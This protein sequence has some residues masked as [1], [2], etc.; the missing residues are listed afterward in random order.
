MKTFGKHLLLLLVLLAALLACASCGGGEVELS[1]KESNLPQTVYVKGSG[2]NLTGGMLTVKEGDTEK[3][4]PLTSEGITVSGYDQNKLGDQTLTVTYRDKTVTFT[5]TVVERLQ[6]TGH[7][8][9]YLVGG[10]LD[11]AKGRLKI[12]RNDG[13][14]YTAV[15][16]DAGVSITG[17]DKTKTGEQIL[18]VTYRDAADTFT[19][20]FP[21]TVYAVESVKLTEPSKIAYNSHESNLLDVTGGRLTLSGKGGA[22][23][24]D[25]PLNADMVTGFDLSAV[26]AQN[27][28]Y[29]QTLTV[30]YDGKTYTYKVKLVYTS[31]SLIKDGLPAFDGLNFGGET[32]PAVTKEVGELALRLISVYLDMPAA[33]KLKLTA[34]ESLTVAR[35]A[36]IYGYGVWSGE[37]E[38]LSDSFAVKNGKLTPAFKTRADAEAA[39]KLLENKESPLYTVAPLLTRTVEAFGDGTV[40]GK[41]TFSSY[42]VLSASL[43]DGTVDL[44][45]YML[46]LSDIFGEIGADWES[47]G[48]MTYETAVRAA[49]ARMCASTFFTAEYAAAH[50]CVAAWGEFD[51]FEALYA[52]FFEKED[53][54][55]IEKLAP[56]CL[57]GEL[58]ELYGYVLNAWTQLALISEYEL[59]DATGFFYFYAKALDA[60]TF[61]R[62]EG[63]AIAELYKTMPINGILGLTDES[64]IYFDTMLEYF[65]T[66]NGGSVEYFAASLLGVEKFERLLGTYIEIVTRVLE[67]EGFEGSAAYGEAVRAMFAAYTALSPTEQ[68]NFLGVISPY[69]YVGYPPLAF[70]DSGEYAPLVSTFVTIL[71]GHF[72]SLFSNE[73][74]AEAYNNLVLAM[75]IYAQRATYE[76]DWLTALDLRLTKANSAYLAMDD[77]DKAVYERYLKALYTKYNDLYKS[78]KNATE[79]DLGDW[80]TVFDAL[81][82]AVIDF[83]NAY[84][85][86][87]DLGYP[88]YNL[89]LSAYERMEAI[90][91]YILEEAPEEVREAYYHANLYKIVAADGTYT[92]SYDYI[93][94]LDRGIYIDCLL[95]YMDNFYVYGAYT[96][97][98]LG[99]FLDMAYDTL[100]SYAWAYVFGQEEVEPPVF[101]RENVLALMAA[102]RELGRDAKLL[103]LSLEGEYGFYYAAVQAFIAEAFSEKASA[104][105]SKTVELEQYMYYL[106]LSN[107]ENLKT[108]KDMLAETKRLYTALAGADKSDF[109]DMEAFY[110]S[111]IAECEKAVAAAESAA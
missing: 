11:L 81:E 93:V 34:E 16:T 23:T 46:E 71:N 73:E 97:E 66:A 13:S 91:A 69:Y 95:G 94:G 84:Y 14:T 63:G 107:A 36:M 85:L 110:A 49:Y 7:V 29:E 60:A 25:I 38:K 19:A 52:Y 80:Q 54:E 72:R 55:A 31:I 68:L 105:A 62:A 102:F 1:V 89:L 28:P 3:D 17:Y 74:A 64:P 58:K 26:N 86:L 4:I 12:T 70:D 61:I 103:F 90:V 101:E 92:Y 41:Q 48:V 111:V 43:F 27:T 88:V 10:E 21:V 50:S 53:T 108:L 37:M 82:Q 104:V 9:D 22:L 109:A 8:T 79:P 56:V 42:S 44:I 83:D 45:A 75:E 57:P 96:E 40:Y 33:D 98:H 32:A 6:V 67:E 100:W 76:G 51:G 2:L 87:G 24:R 78:H 35:A 65:R 30:T 5:V 106:D 39:K 77:T 15:L 59:Y 47:V 20:T 99:R 18:T